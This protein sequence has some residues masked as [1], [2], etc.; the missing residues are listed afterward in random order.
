VTTVLS[1]CDR[2]GVMVQPWLEAGFDAV[3]VDLQAD[4]MTEQ[5]GSARWERVRCNVRDYHLRCQ[6]AVVFAFPPCTH[7]ASSGARW[8]RDKGLGKLIEALTTVEACRQLCESS[9][10]PWM[11][12]NP[13]GT[14]STYWRDPDYLFDPCDFAGWCDDPDTEAYTKR[15]CLWTGGGFVYPRRRWVEPTL[16]SLF[17]RTPPGPDRGDIRSVTPQGFARAVFDANVDRVREKAA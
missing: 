10:A 15:T 7:L 11:V 9:G 4:D 5:V 16:G 3:T 12:E 1:L 6:P 14:L 8:F 13:V 2:T 17:H